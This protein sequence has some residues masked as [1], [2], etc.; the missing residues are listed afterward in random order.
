M[1]DKWKC[2]DD[3]LCGVNEPKDKN[4]LTDLEQKHAIT[5]NAPD[6][7]KKDEPFEVILKVGEQKE[8]PNEVAHFIEWVEL[9]CGDTFIGQAHFSGGASFPQTVF[10][11]KLSHAHG[12]LKAWEKCNIHGLWENKKEITVE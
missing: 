7:V 1:A 6:K 8:H 3:I 11:V 5:I 12:P 10:K 4:N 9:Y 2:E